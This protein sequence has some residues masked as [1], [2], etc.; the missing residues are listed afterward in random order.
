MKRIILLITLL[1]LTSCVESPTSHI[2]TQPEQCEKAV[3]VF[4]LPAN[5]WESGEIYED[6]YYKLWLADE[7]F[8]LGEYDANR[9]APMNVEIDAFDF[10][11]ATISEDGGLYISIDEIAKQ[12]NETFL[13]GGH[14][15]EAIVDVRNKSK[16]NYF[17]YNTKI[18]FYVGCEPIQFVTPKLESIRVSN[19][20]Y[21]FDDLEQYINLTMEYKVIETKEITVIIPRES[22]FKVLACDY[23]D[24]AIVLNVH[25]YDRK[26]H[27]TFTH[28]RKAFELT[29]AREYIIKIDFWNSNSDEIKVECEL[30]DVEYY[31]SSYGEIEIDV[32]TDVYGDVG[33][34]NPKFEFTFI[35]K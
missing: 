27:Q 21:F 5:D 22:P 25:E 14:Y 35:K 29:D 8:Y 34:E 12:F 19:Q 18:Q 2:A 32:M 6:T 3:R 11:D 26:L 4:L 7:N 16:G 28:H 20:L 17:I 30:M 13:D 31:M 1:L 9:D 23:Y 24:D 10:R 33:Q 15:F